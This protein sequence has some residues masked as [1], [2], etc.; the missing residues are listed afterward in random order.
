[1][2]KARRRRKSGT[3]PAGGPSRSRRIGI[4]L[5]AVALFCAALYAM[6]FVDA[7]GPDR[8]GVSRDGAPPDA[9]ID[10]ASRDR[11]REIL[12]EEEDGE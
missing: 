12:R 10:D 8:P 5:L 2:A 1:M 9:H 3:A 6:F 11:L 7:I 4:V